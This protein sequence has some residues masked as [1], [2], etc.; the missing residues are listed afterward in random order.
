LTRA[1][2]QEQLLT[3]WSADSKTETVLMV[4]HGI[5][6]AV[7]LADRIVVMANAPMPS[8]AE[9]VDV[10]IPRPRR[11][12]GLPLHPGFLA[13]HARLTELLEHELADEEEAA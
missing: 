12:A 3:L 10:D 7:F 6:E 5:D 2:L 4:T 13:A 9:I 11:R 1:R 8:I